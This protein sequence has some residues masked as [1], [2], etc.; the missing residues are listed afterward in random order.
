MAA[1]LRVG[2]VI[3]GRY[4]ILE[5]LG[6]GA[7]GFVYRVEDGERASGAAPA[8]ELALKLHAPKSGADAAWSWRLRR[9]FYLMSQLRHPNI[10]GV[11]DWGEEPP[12]LYYTMDLVRGRDAAALA[13]LSSE[14]VT[15]VLVALA[16]A[17]GLI[18]A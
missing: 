12:Y 14:A 13:P 16:D 5:V 11:R 7:A 8:R 9:E 15:D 3:S 1:A 17:L 2:D 18:H 10:V 6:R 4:R